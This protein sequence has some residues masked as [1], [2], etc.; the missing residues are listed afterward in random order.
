MFFQIVGSL[1]IKSIWLLSFRQI[2]AIGSE[3]L[4]GQII[5]TNSASIAK[6]LA[7]IGIELVQTHNRGDDLQRMERTLHEAMGRSAVVITTGGIESTEDDLTRKR[8]PMS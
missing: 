1:K 7:E 5:D 8:W 6:R 3:L 2:V 4:L